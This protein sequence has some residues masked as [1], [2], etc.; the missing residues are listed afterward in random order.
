MEKHVT[1]VTNDVVALITLPVAFTSV[2]AITTVAQ[3]QGQPGYVPP[4]MERREADMVNQ[5]E[6]RERE[7]LRRRLGARSVRVTNPRYLQAVIAQVKED[8]ERIQVIRNDL[9]RSN[10]ANNGL[11]YK[12]ISEATEE[13]KKRSSRLKNNLALPDSE[14]NEKIQKSASEFDHAQIKDALN[15]LC[16]RIES[17]VK[18]SIFETPGVIDAE[19]SVKANDDLRSIVEL[20]SNIRKG[21]QRLGKT[22]K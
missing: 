4:V 7:S 14:E 18:S 11:D 16:D 19:V 9:V 20:S 17:F 22:I 1:K 6:M 5:R 2:L 3:Q 12:F 13:I 10:S 15:K 8:F 21:A